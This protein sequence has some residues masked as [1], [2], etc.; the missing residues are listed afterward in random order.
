M[1]S[2][3]ERVD[4]STWLPFGEQLRTL[5]NGDHIATGDLATLARSKGLFA[6][7]IDR[8]RIVQ[9]LST[10]LLQP[11]EISKLLE[12]S[13]TREARPKVQPQK[14]TLTSEDAD[15]QTTIKRA[16]QGL[17]DVVN[18]ARSS[19]IS[20]TQEPRL[21]SHD[22]RSLTI[23]YVINR[24]DYSR[25]LLHREL[26][27]KAE[28]AVR[29]SDGA[30]TLDVISTHT[31]KETDRINDQIIGFLTRELKAAG[32][33]KDNA[34]AKIRLGSF[35]GK[36]H[37]TFLLRLAGPAIVGKEAGKIVDLAIKPN[38]ASGSDKL[39]PELAFLEGQI[40]NMRMEGD[41][42][43]GISLLANETYHGMYVMARVLV[44]HSFDLEGVRGKC[45]ILFQFQIGRGSDDFTA[46][47][48]SFA[49]ESVSVT[50]ARKS[51]STA[52]AKKLINA[53]VFA[54]ID[55]N[56]AALRAR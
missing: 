27:F 12:D 19:G 34:P 11:F 14:V 38:T 53:A 28:I 52:K 3:S 10:T 54:A 17:A 47:P 8:P 44:A 21:H 22:R 49:V 5:L 15:W 45:S 9:F 30:S 20:F 23:S 26:S 56:F 40:R 48:F 4:V 51:D 29:Q 13:A 46:A 39:P 36:G 32:L 6:S 43:N 50:G 35:D 33:S 1:L 31:A 41:A 55:R 7:G 42:L 24:E 16:E 37:V 25:D 2:T 18:L